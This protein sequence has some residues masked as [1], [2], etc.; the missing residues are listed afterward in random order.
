MAADANSCVYNQLKGPR[1]LTMLG[2]EGHA[3]RDHPV[4][5]YLA[6]FLLQHNCFLCLLRGSPRNEDASPPLLR[7]EGTLVA[8]AVLGGLSSALNAALPAKLL[9]THASQ[10][11]CDGN[12]HGREQSP[13]SAVVCMGAHS[14]LGNC[15]SGMRALPYLKYATAVFMLTV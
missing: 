13:G 3:R 7:G 12:L 10:S 11:N 5:W 14:L 8:L 6:L 9:Q 15:I 1:E 4:R 2:M